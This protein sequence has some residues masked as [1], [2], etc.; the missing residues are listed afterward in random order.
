M[1]LLNLNEAQLTDAMK[2]IMSAAKAHG[3][4]GWGGEC[5]A[6]AIAMNKAL[7]CGGATYVIAFNA[8][9]AE[10]GIY[11]GHAA[12]KVPADPQAGREFD[13]L[14]DADGK[15]KSLDEIE[16]W[17]MLDPDDSDWRDLAQEHNVNWDEDSAFCAEISMPD[18]A[19]MSSM[20]SIDNTE[21]LINIIEE[22][23][24]SLQ[25]ESST[26]NFRTPSP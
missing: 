17:G 20:T 21:E 12:I 6:T 13:L 25:I 19:F 24:N 2:D 10:A 7:F 15:P 14:F 5:W 1:N 22:C 3:V 23:A 9:L 4:T 18:D 8:P 16:A 26:L 11:I